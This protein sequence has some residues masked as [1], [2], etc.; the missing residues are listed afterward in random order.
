[1]IGDM[2]AV[3][4]CTRVENYPLPYCSELLEFLAGAE[5]YATI[6]LMSGFFQVPIAEADKVKTTIHTPKGPK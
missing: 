4:S 6:D 1:M 2:R 3:N 5:W